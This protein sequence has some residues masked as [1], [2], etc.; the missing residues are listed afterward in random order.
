L[1]S[2]TNIAIFFALKIILL[3]KVW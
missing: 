3:M 1:L 2:F